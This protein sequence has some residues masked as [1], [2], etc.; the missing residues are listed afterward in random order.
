MDDLPPPKISYC[1][2]NP[3]VLPQFDG[4]ISVS[5]SFTDIDLDC[6]T[7]PQSN[8]PLIGMLRI[9]TIVGLR[10]RK[11]ILDRGSPCWRRI[12]RENN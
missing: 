12:R 8:Y 1:I 3:F 6:S 5:S 2:E 11:V 4:N 7:R 9:P 10:P